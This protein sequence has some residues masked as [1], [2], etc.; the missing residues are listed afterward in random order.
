MA[1]TAKSV[2]FDFT[3]NH[4]GTSWMGIRSVDF[5]LSGS[6]ITLTEADY[7]CYESSLYSGSFYT[8]YAFDTSLTKTGAG[9]LVSWASG[10]SVV[11]DSRIIVVFDEEQTFDAI[12]INNYHSSGT[13][14]GLW[15]KNNKN[16]D[17]TGSIYYNNI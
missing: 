1:Y 17:H 12:V 4:G 3:D 5:Y 14:Y 7:T 16:N 6:K 15:C 13:R 8:K 2:I 11:T 10:S 9:G